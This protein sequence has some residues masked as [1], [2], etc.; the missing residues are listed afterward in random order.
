MPGGIAQLAAYGTADSYLT[1]SPQI[2]WFRSVTRRHTLFSLEAIDQ[3]FDGTADFG[4]KSSVQLSRNGDLVSR[5][6]VQV[7]LPDLAAYD[8]TPT[9]AEGQ[10]VDV[11]KQGSVTSSTDAGDLAGTSA[12]RVWK[13]SSTIFAYELAGKRYT[14]AACTAEIKTWPYMVDDDGD[15]VA[16]TALVRWCNSIGHALMSSVE[17]EI[18][19]QR[20]DRHFSEWWDIWSELTE[21]EEKRAGLWD[22]VGKYSAADYATFQREHAAAKT[23][24]VP[25]TF[26]FNRHPGLALPLVALTYHAVKFNLEFRPYLECIRSSVPVTALT[27]K[28]GGL[29]P[30]FADIKLFAE[31]VFLDTPE[32]RRF[33]QM[34]HEYLFEQVQWLGDEAVLPTA[35][36]RKFQ[37]AFNHP[38]KELVWVYVPKTHYDADPQTGNQIF[39]YHIPDLADQD[40]FD[41][42]KLLLNGNDRFS[43]RPPG[44]FRRVQPYQHHTRCPAKHI[45]AY[46]FALNPEDIQPSGTCNWSRLDSAQLQ[47]KLNDNIQLGRVKIYALSYNVVRIQS[48][49]AGLQFSS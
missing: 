46:S 35:L 16:P 7:Q 36:N 29:T 15:Y 31:Y 18:G 39:D 11:T 17:L 38:V 14:D 37:L 34:P 5:V 23:L 41:S 43:E 30:S 2:T 19:G 12:T 4:R 20:I 6:W 42:A 40:V 1:S 25:L 44:Y 8:I 45:Y 24:Y 28:D 13:K 49:M 22:M 26:C 21:K 32:R 3:V 48:G 27:S 9:P 47:L 33:A 10:S